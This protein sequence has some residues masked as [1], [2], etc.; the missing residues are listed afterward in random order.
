MQFQDFSQR[1]A[2]QELTLDSDDKAIAVL[3]EEGYDPEFG[4]R[5]VKRALQKLLE[6]PVAKAIIAGK[7][8]P[9]ATIRVTAKD[10]AL[11]LV[12]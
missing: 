2:E 5:P 9:G 3:A 7:Y 4:A 8:P 6:N 10:G 11:I 12:N 1:L